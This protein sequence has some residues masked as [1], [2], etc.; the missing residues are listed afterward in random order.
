MWNSMFEK[1][2]QRMT[3]MYAFIFGMLILLVV[4]ATYC[5]VWYAVLVHEKKDLV[6]QIYHEAEEYV[7][8][9]EA[10]V[11]DVAIKNGSMLA[12][13]V[14]PDDKTVVLDQLRGAAVGDIIKDHRDDWPETDDSASM[15]RMRDDGGGRYRYLAAVAPVKDGNK[16]IG[17]L[18]M[19]KNMDFY[20]RAAS[21]TLFMLLCISLLLFIPTCI[22]GYWLSKRNI[23]P[24]Y[25]MYERQKQ[26][27][28]DASHE[29]RTPLSVLNLAVSGLLE[30]CDSKYSSFARETLQMMQTEVGR[31]RNLTDTL[32]ELARRD[33]SG[34][35]VKKEKI[36]LNELCKRVISQFSM[37][38]EKEQR[39]ITS[40]MPEHIFVRGDHDSLN[41][42]LI[43]LLDN[44]FKYSPAASAIEVSVERKRDHIVLRVADQG[45]GISDEDKS[46]IFDRFYRV[47]KVRS[48]EQGG[49]GLG[50]SLALS[51]V[52]LHR[53]KINALDNKPRG[54]IMQVVLPK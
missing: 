53:G 47:D 7:A 25:Q 34:L 29:M 26:F 8:T 27:T 35:P 19:F 48:R 49:L 40:I 46:K 18:Y 5:L 30:D 51:I 24:I 22:L 6:A 23:R 32:M 28:A 14:R 17:R 15:I 9:E 39:Q 42:L 45:I 3:F 2:R 10:P 43:I 44:A 38:A 33:N 4:A 36:D 31:L 41:M 21:E 54:T 50:L 13:L 16:V 12:F 11:S 1:L 20:Y 37:L 52:R